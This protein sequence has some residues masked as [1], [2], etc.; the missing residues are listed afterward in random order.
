MRFKVLIT[1]V[2]FTALS[3][4]CGS[5]D[6]TLNT[7]P[8]GLA[9]LTGV[10]NDALRSAADKYGVQPELLAALAYQQSRIESLQLIP[11]TTPVEPIVL[12]PGEVDHP[13]NHS[14]E[15]DDVA[16]FGVMLLDET[17]IQQA[18]ELTG[19]S[20][21]QIKTDIASNIDAAA[22]L[23]QK[24]ASVEVLAKPMSSDAFRVAAVRFVGLDPESEAGKL[25]DDSINSLIRDGFALTT[26]DGER[27][28][29]YGFAPEATAEKALTAGAYPPIQFIQS[30]NYD[31]RGGSPVQFVVIHDMEGYQA[32]A[33]SSFQNPAR[34]ASAHYLLR[35]SDGHIVQMVSEGSNAW[36]CGNYYYNQH[37]IG[38]EH[39]G[40]ADQPG[41]GGYYTAT[42][43]S[44]SAQLVCAIVKKYGIAVD[45]AHI[46]GHG[47]VPRSGSGGLCSDAAAN[48]G[49]CGGASGH[50]D[51]GRY[52]DWAGY[53]NQIAR[54]A[55]G[56]SLPPPP[57]PPPPPGGACG[58][59]SDGK[60]HCGNTAGAT[61]YA[62]ANPTSGIVNH[63]RTTYSWFDCFAFGAPHSGGNSTWYHTVGDDNSNWGYVPAVN[64]QT[65]SGF[66]A[67]PA[68][69]GLRQCAGATPPPPQSS[70]CNVHADGKLYCTNSA[71][72]P[73]YA[74]A[75]GG[76]IVNHLRTTS[77]WFDCFSFGA[78]HAGGN[79]T[80]YHTIGDDNGN[81]GWVPAVHLNTAGAFDANPAAGGL[82]SCN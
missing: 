66:D 32:G 1:L 40:F 82:R 64:L 49:Q 17:Q 21:D 51:P 67:N 42:Q 38:I 41:G 53:L 59:Q 15:H 37:S 69:G 57:P 79:H 24:L 23:L 76:A 44:A 8:K 28:V 68:A 73:I 52:W 55:G 10:R 75:N 20:A 29:L 4:G 34:Q 18:A 47:N 74:S 48:A 26:S 2:G 72:A 16:R 35:A 25:S 81:W 71:G 54:C 33:I 22:A 65:S 80:W 6:A 13:S 63:L 56:S 62:A 78:L 58:V 60:L 46:F 70:T 9:E 50:H 77:S 27:V 36:H 5:A 30:P 31:S 11:D 14:I 39:E 43:Y 7:E 45:R 3:V 19:L 12:A 61:M